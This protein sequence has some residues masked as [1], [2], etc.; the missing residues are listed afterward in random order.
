MHWPRCPMEGG[1]K[2]IEVKS[3]GECPYLKRGVYCN[4]PTGQFVVAARA[5][6]IAT[7]IIPSW[8]PLPDAGRRGG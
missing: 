4:V 3:C 5:V 1:M 6:D 7:Y 8:C 2:I